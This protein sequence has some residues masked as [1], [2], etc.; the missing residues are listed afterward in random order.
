MSNSFWIKGHILQ[1]CSH[2]V[3]LLGSEWY[4]SS[5]ILHHH[6]AHNAHREH[7]MTRHI[8][9]FL[10]CAQRHLKSSVSHNLPLTLV[11]HVCRHH[12]LEHTF[13]LFDLLNDCMGIWNNLMISCANLNRLFSEL[14]DDEDVDGGSVWAERT[15]EKMREQTKW[16]KC[17]CIA[18]FI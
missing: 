5:C 3:R 7:N 11:L 12:L 13:S 14:Q 18:L 15:P 6:R 16:L 4:C 10:F 8:F 1:G 17:C 2:W 9:C